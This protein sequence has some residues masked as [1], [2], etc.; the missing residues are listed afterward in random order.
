MHGS[1]MNSMTLAQMQ[2][3][4]KAGKTKSDFRRVRREAAA[5]IEPEADRDSPNATRRMQAALKRGRPRLENPKQLL[6]LR[7]APDV[8]E[9]WRATGPG[10]QTRMASVLE[11]AIARSR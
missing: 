1:K 4:R 9:R 6:T 10:W 3:S 11:H 8:I 2:A 7:V 5:G